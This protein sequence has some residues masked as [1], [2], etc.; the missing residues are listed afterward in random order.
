MIT[1]NGYGHLQNTAFLYIEQLAIAE[2]SEA[3]C[4]QES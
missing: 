2:V 1:L 3:L 4:A